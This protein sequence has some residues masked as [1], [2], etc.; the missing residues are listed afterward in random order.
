MFQR[1]RLD[2]ELADELESHLSL[3]V[4]D[5]VRAGM[6]TE[7]ARR[8][9]RLKLGGVAQVEQQYRHV[10]GVPLVE[11]VMCDVRFGA[12]TLRAAP[13]FTAVAV[14][15][16]GLGIGANAAIFSV[17]NAALLQPFPVERP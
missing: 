10:R 8:H 17:I 7:E 2:R 15:T 11:H 6:T 9:A 12:R 14:L 5:N 4:D 13:L 16:L 1:D 3:H